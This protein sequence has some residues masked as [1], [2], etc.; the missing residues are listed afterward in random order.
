M[1]DEQPEKDLE[2][3]YEDRNLLA[4]AFAKLSPYRAGWQPDPGSPEKWA[5]VWVAPPGVD[6]MGWHVPRRTVE[7]LELP[8][9][10]LEYDGHTRDQKNNRLREL[11]AGRKYQTS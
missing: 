1:A 2:E 10:R 6:Q 9:E 7:A 11:T 8:R 3:V 4:V 5:I